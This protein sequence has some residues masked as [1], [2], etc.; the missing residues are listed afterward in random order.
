[1]GAEA[2]TLTS[3]LTCASVR[4]PGTLLQRLDRLYDDVEWVV[5][6]VEQAVED[7]TTPDLAASAWCELSPR[8]HE[9]VAAWFWQLLEQQQASNPI[10]G[11][12]SAGRIL[13]QQRALP[14]GRAE[15]EMD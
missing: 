2:S 9:A 7:A 5:D 3:T 1:M 11:P 4:R 15:A 10:L 6:R 8:E 12:E 14:Q 13:E